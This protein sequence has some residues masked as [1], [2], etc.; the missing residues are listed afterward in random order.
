M[1]YNKISLLLRHDDHS[2]LNR[3]ISFTDIL[4]IL[5]GLGLCIQACG[6]VDATKEMENMSLTKNDSVHPMA[7][8]P[9]DVSVPAKTETATFAL[10]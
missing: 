10:G 6:R 7:R 4:F 1:N 2:N 9:I 3:R 8:P 5:L